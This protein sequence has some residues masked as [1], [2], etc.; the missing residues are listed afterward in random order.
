MDEETIERSGTSDSGKDMSQPAEGENA[1]SAKNNDSVPDKSTDEKKIKK[2]LSGGKKNR[3]KIII[4]LIIVIAVIAA[5]FSFCTIR[6]KQKNAGMQEV[7]ANVE[8]RSITNTVT[9]SSTVEANDS[10]DVSSMVQGEVLSDTFSEGDHV[11][12]DQVLYEIDSEDAQ[13]NVENAQNSLRKAQLSYDDAVYNNKSTSSNILKAKDAL[14]KAQED[15]ADTVRKLA[16]NDR[17]VQQAVNSVTKAQN[18]YKTAADDMDNL[19]IAAESAGTVSAVY[20]SNGDSVSN[21]TKIADI[22]N[23]RYMKLSVPFNT[24][25]ADKIHNGDAAVVKV[26]GHS[27][28]IFATVTSVSS[29]EVATDAHAVVRYVTVELTNP[30]ALTINDKGTVTIGGVTCQ[31]VANFEYVNTE[32][33]TAKVSGKVYSLNIKENDRVEQGTVV[34]NLS[35][36]TVENTLANAEIELDNANMSLQ[37]AILQNDSVAQNNAVKTAQRALDEA[38]ASYD[39]TVRSQGQSVTTAAIELANAKLSLD[40]A[41]KTLEDYTIK[42]PIAGT[43]VTKNVKAGDKLE[44]STSNANTSQMAVIYDLTCLKFEL[45]IDET[46]IQKVKVGQEVTVTADAVEGSFTGVVQKVGVDGTAENGVTTYPVEV[47]IDNYGDLLPG[48]NVDASIE[49]ESAENVLAIPLSSV[50]RGNVVY[51]KGDKTDENDKAPEGYKSVTVEVGINDNTYVEIKSGLNEGDIVKGA[52]AASGND[53]TG[54]AQQ[55]QQMGGMPGG[56]SGGM[57][58]GMPG[59]GGGMGGGMPGG[60]R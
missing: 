17:A 6:N 36:D 31:D 24:A 1:A 9:G 21:G 39:S 53:T 38:K 15:L 14:L 40:N 47:R 5:G 51:V 59:G 13:S 29:A 52:D 12:K 54:T 7:T 44:N 8:R 20:V 30:G 26:A 45:S 55:Q 48:M 41:N 2:I 22:Y 33:I 35:S 46:E 58:G 11:E 56:M 49:V 32:S 60:G 16:S 34:V 25:D 42:A 4:M 37:D 57:G 10:Y 23:D 27:D 28:E 50:N 3:K 43:I 19:N 18:S